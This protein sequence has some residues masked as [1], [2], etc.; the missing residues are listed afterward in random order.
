MEIKELI[1]TVVVYGIA[2]L[3]PLILM[4]VLDRKSKE[5]D[6]RLK[7]EDLEEQK[8]RRLSR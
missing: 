7:E 6:K 3:V 1:A 4:Y 2:I 8:A 5:I